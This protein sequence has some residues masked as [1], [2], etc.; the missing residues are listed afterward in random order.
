M[1]G[2]GESRSESF[3][4]IGGDACQFHRT[5]HKGTNQLKGAAILTF[6]STVVV[7]RLF[8][9]EHVIQSFAKVG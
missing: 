5:Q 8:H 7:L 4:W 1:N 9:C 3:E 2:D 6:L